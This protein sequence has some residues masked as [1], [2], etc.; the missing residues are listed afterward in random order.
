MAPEQRDDPATV[1][2]RADIYALGAMAYEMLTGRPPFTGA[3]PQS[4]LAAQVTQLPDHVT[5]HRA[6]VPPA[7]AEAV[8]RCLA[9]KPADRFQQA[10]ELVPLFD[11]LL[12]PSGGMTPAGTQP[13]PAVDYDARARRANPLRVGG[14]FV[15]AGVGVAAIVYAL[16]RV[17]GL[18]NWVFVAGVGLLLAGLPVMLVTGAQ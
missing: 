6:T 18:P 7:L 12:T 4:V 13:V 5:M 14:L 2:H 9:K 10:E 3:T 16:V 15:L 17:I 11:S 1:D 8:M